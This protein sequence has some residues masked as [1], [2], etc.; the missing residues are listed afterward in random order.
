MS[1]GGSYRVIIEL[2]GLA[3]ALFTLYWWC[4]LSCEVVH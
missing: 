2:W 4:L 3:I 1:Y